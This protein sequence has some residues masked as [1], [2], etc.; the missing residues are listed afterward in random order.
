MP[1][2][3]PTQTNQLRESLPSPIRRIAELFFP[4]KD[5]TLGLSPA[6]LSVVEGAVPGLVKSLKGLTVPTKA[7]TNTLVHELASRGSEP[8]PSTPARAFIEHLESLVPEA[9]DPN[10]LAAIDKVTGARPPTSPPIH[11][12]DGFKFLSPSAHSRARGRMV[13]ELAI[14]RDPV[15]DP[16]QNTW[17]KLDELMK[18]RTLNTQ[19]PASSSLE[20]PK[21]SG[22]WNS[23]NNNPRNFKVDPLN[24]ATK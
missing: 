6:P 22:R 5:P 12:P 2:V 18:T 21:L 19:A 13:D 24:K 11:A 23:K 16:L 4:E 3:R 14:K 10:K 15:M 8:P 9:A 1:V 7:E 17:A 20:R